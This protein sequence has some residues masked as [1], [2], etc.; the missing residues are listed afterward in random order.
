MFRDIGEPR[1]FSFPKV[2]RYAEGV[3]E[4]QVRLRT[5]YLAR[6]KITI[7]SGSASFVDK[8]TIDIIVRDNTKKRL[9][10]SEAVIATGSSPWRPSNIDFSHP[11]VYDS[12]TILQ[13][14]HTP[15]TIII[16]GA[17]VIGCEYAS[18][19]SGLGA[20]VDLIHP[21]DRLLTFL[22][23]EISDALSYHLRD[24]GALIRHNEQFD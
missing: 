12:D 18:I 7:I 16:Y 13:L 23:D 24:K 10:F 6:N 19:F 2:L 14:E 5:E 4:K 11:R 1:W 17:G 21:G 20:M 15:R 22:D 9:H 8:N 3:I